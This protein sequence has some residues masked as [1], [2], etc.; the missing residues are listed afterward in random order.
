MEMTGQIISA[1][2][3]IYALRQA[4]LGPT[5][6]RLRMALEEAGLDYDI[7]PMSTIVVGEIGTVLGALESAMTEA[8]AMG[9]VVMNLTLS[10]ACPTSL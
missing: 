2:V 6:E 7:G 5:V 1:Q 9:H 10:N 3:S 4:E 8:C